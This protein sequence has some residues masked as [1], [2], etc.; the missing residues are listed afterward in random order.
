MEIIKGIVV[1]LSCILLIF[2]ISLPQGKSK[3]CPNCQAILTKQDSLKI[4]R[5]IKQKVDS[6]VAVKKCELKEIADSLRKIEKKL[7]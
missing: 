7:P 3:K 5:E 2:G 4:S 1:C 6:F